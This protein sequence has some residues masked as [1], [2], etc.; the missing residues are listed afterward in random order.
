MEDTGKTLKDD[1]IK[2]TLG[3]GNQSAICGGIKPMA[4]ADVTPQP[5]TQPTLDEKK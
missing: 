2:F 4:V 1:S 5:E 3:S